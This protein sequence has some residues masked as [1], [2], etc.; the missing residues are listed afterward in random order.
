MQS[1]LDTLEK[2]NSP[3][4]RVNSPTNSISSIDSNKTIK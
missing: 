4:D 1:Q 2:I 3:I